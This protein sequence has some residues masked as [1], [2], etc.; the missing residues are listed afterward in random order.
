M[1]CSVAIIWSCNVYY[2]ITMKVTGWPCFLE[3]V[4]KLGDAPKW[5]I[6]EFDKLF[7]LLQ[8]FPQTYTIC[9]NLT[10]LVLVLR[11]LFHTEHFQA[12]AKYFVF[13]LSCLFVGFWTHQTVS[14]SSVAC[15]GCAEAGR[16]L[17]HARRQHRSAR[18]QCSDGWQESEHIGHRSC[19]YF[20]VH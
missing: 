8:Y 17:Q 9:L 3:H 13:I 14:S 11:C 20:Y 1:I 18:L 7:L 12:G 15:C 10:T 2:T 19:I 6:S 4:Y 16:P 5:E